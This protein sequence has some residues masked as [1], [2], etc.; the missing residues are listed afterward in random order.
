MLSFSIASF[1]DTL[2]ESDRP[3]V[4]GRV[5]Q[6]TL[7][8]H[9]L[10]ESFLDWKRQQYK[11]LKVETRDDTQRERDRVNQV[12]SR[13]LRD[14]RARTRQTAL[15]FVTPRWSASPGPTPRCPKWYSGCTSTATDL[16]STL[17][18]KLD[19]TSFG[20]STHRRQAIRQGSSLVFGTVFDRRNQKYK[21]SARE[22]KNPRLV[23]LVRRLVELEVPDFKYT[24]ITVNKNVVT[25]PHKDKYN[26]GPTLLLGLGNFRGGDL[27]VGGNP[28]KI[29]CHRWL[30]FWGKDEHYNTALTYGTKYTITLFTLLPPLAS[31]DAQTHTLVA[32][33]A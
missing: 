1:L 22:S 7:E 17:L 33:M 18:Q 32:Q 12:V 8:S 6:K 19:A 14:G 21:T 30:Y 15:A 28:F 10:L 26:V 9:G 4:S 25:N 13:A 16:R 2:R 3:F 29:S 27:V 31:P 20:S 23:D 11:E 5:T 24:T